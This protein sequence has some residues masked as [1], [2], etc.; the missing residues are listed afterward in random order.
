MAEIRVF[1]AESNH[2]EDFYFGRFDGYAA[3]EVLIA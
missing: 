2:A 3:N 1:I